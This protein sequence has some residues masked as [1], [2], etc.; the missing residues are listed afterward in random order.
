[1]QLDQSVQQELQVQ[2]VQQ[3]TQDR[4]GQLALQGHKAFKAM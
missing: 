2:L 3:V 1:V 4:Q